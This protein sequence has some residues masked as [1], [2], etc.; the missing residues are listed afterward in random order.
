MQIVGVLIVLAAVASLASIG[1]SARPHW[2][3]RVRQRR[4][5]E[6]GALPELA[7]HEV[8]VDVHAARVALA[9]GEPRNAIIACWMQLER[10]AASAGLARAEAETSAEYA[11]RVVALSSV[12]PI[13]IR[14]LAALYREARFSRHDLTDD[15][16]ARASTA[17]NR[18]A[19][20]LRRGVEVA[21]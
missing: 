17:L 2:R 11:E 3:R 9:A 4:D 1:R 5:R 18:V 16:R 19:A 6:I 12:D 7:E 14:E 15:H 21:T 10:D 8:T 20:A 13:P